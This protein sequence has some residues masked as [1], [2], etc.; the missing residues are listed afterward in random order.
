MD[1]DDDDDAIAQ[2][3]PSNDLDRILHPDGQDEPLLNKLTR[4]WLDER[5]APDILIWQGL[6]VEDALDKMQAQV[7][8]ESRA[9]AGNN[10]LSLAFSFWN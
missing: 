10:W 7:R 1:E 5:N 2:N 9:F 6:A 8:S 4:H 3:A